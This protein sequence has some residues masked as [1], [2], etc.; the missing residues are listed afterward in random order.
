MTTSPPLSLAHAQLLHLLAEGPELEAFLTEAVRLAADSVPNAH[1]C[2]M[3][4]SRDL[5]A[6]TA[7]HSDS[8]AAQID[9]LQY[10]AHEGPC[11]DALHTGRLIEV[12]DLEKEQRWQR[13]RPH[14]L[15]HGVAASLSHPLNVDGQ[16]V[17]VLN[18]YARRPHAFTP[19]DRQHAAILASQC[20]AALTVM[21]R[22]ADQTLTQRQLAEAMHARSVIDQA[23]GILMAQQRCTAE[24]A[25]DLLRAASSGRNRKLR[26]IAAD[27]IEKATGHPPQPPAPF[28]D[29]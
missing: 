13:Y 14:A 18:L 4:L 15:E 29:R 27:L 19:A 22:Q 26:E 11:L 21:L 12:D 25:F 5:R 20:A 16:T 23:L 2:G 17:A 7:A 1:A 3:T 8:L 10:G 28:N 9:E 24:Q 6:F